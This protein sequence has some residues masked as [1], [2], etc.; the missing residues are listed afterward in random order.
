[1]NRQPEMHDFMTR[2]AFNYLWSSSVLFCMPHPWLSFPF[3]LRT[4]SLQKTFPTVFTRISEFLLV[5]STNVHFIKITL[6]WAMGSSP[7]HASLFLTDVPFPLCSFF[8]PFPFLSYGD[9]YILFTYWWTQKWEIEPLGEIFQVSKT[10]FLE[11]CLLLF[12][13]W[14]I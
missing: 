9:V 14:W 3:V 1:M 10:W 13:E 11:T 12:G 8:L 7:H 2:F 4:V 5:L 6:N